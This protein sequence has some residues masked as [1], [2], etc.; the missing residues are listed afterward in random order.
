VLAALKRVEA[1]LASLQASLRRKPPPTPKPPRATSL[2][3]REASRI[4]RLLSTVA[5]ELTKRQIRAALGLSG[6]TCVRALR[7]AIESGA[8]VQTG[9]RGAP[10][11]AVYAA[12]KGGAAL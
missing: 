4:A 6:T 1:R 9:Y 10:R 8:V 5:D 2:A 12:R 11:R 7:I 3:A